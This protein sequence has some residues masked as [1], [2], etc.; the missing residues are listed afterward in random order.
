MK[1]ISIA[2]LVEEYSRLLA[3]SYL[4]IRLYTQQVAGKEASQA[5]HSHRLDRAIVAWHL[6]KASKIA[7]NS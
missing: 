3:M 5:A 2:F 4:T 6:Y 7:L 1:H